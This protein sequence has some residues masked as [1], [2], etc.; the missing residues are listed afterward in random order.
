MH[1][2]HRFEAGLCEVYAGL[3][4]DHRY[5]HQF[6]ARKLPFAQGK[7]PEGPGAGGGPHGVA[8]DPRG[9]PHKPR[10][11]RR[12]E[13]GLPGVERY[14]LGRLVPQGFPD[15]GHLEED[16]GE[17][18]SWS[19]H[20]AR[21]LVEPLRGRRLKWPGG[22]ASRRPTGGGGERRRRPFWKP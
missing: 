13:R 19:P 20:L 8:G 17:E 4:S 3:A 9:S 22:G 18:G 12:G 10:K 6:H 5:K 21:A 16:G 7:A 15:P 1:K 11:G 2:P 14:A